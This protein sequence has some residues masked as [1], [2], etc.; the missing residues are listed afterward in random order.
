[1]S[2]NVSKSVA[3][4][5]A[6]FELLRERRQPLTA[7]AIRGELGVPQPSLR[8]LLTKLVDLDYL[9]F[10]PVP[11]TYFPTPKLAALGQFDAGL[12]RPDSRWRSVI[13]R[14]TAET[15]ET[16]SL[17]VAL[18]LELE[19]LYACM[20]DHPV[21]L[22]LRSGR[23]HALWRSAAGRGVARR[24]ATRHSAGAVVPRRRN[25]RTKNRLT[26]AGSQRPHE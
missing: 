6:V 21:A 19:V 13:D 11:R 26:T 10:D 14:I 2:D 20:A 5:F 1:M 25:E 16:T 15:G 8:A 7:A 3:R 9:S 18:G 24:R 12:V 22:Q 4:T 23:G 17:C